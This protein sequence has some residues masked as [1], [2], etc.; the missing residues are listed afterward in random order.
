MAKISV[1]GI[2]GMS[3]FMKVDHFHQL[4]ETLIADDL[5][6]EVGGKGINQ[7]IAASRMEEKVSFL[8][9]VGDDSHGKEC[10]EVARQNNIDA[11][12]AIKENKKTAIAYILTDKDGNNQVTEFMGAVLDVSDVM[13][14]EEEISNSDILLLQQEIPHEVN[15]KAIEIAK[16]YDVKVILNPA[17]PRKIDD[18]IVNDVYVI[19]PNEQE[20]KFIDSGRFKN[21]VTTLGSN[22]CIIN[23][24]TIID[25]LKVD[26][27]DT[28]GAG[29]AFNGVLASFIAEGE[30]LENSARYAVVASGI[31]V[32]RKNVLNAIPYRKEILK[33]VKNNDK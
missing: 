6:F 1:I 19:T 12:F 14:F 21:V 7:A 17:P 31:S 20:A 30:N 33:G 24:K 2:C 4:G 27:V 18:E 25:A 9:A 10:M 22:G 26:A 23:E 15:K 3:I 11:T 16:K 32:T 28:T 5:F 29:D 8:T 13:R